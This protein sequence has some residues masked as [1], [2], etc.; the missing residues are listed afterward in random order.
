M[1]N[2]KNKQLNIKIDNESVPTT[3][4][5]KILG[6]TLDSMWKFGPHIQ[7]LK[8]RTAN[9]T[10]ILKSLAGST[11]GKDKEVLKTT[12]KATGQSL[13]NY[14]NHIYTPVIS[15]TN[16]N[17][18]QV[19]QNAALRAATGCVKMTPI[20]H[21]HAEY[22]E[23]QFMNIATCSPLSISLEHNSQVIQIIPTWADLL[24]IT[25]N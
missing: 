18:L 8:Q 3:T 15:D 12:W 10:N 13:L 7:N 5:P 25:S 20:G 23:I 22:K 16:W 1:R 2:E 11:W 14:C 4:T 6:C 17:K 24:I 21:L 9:R 19:S